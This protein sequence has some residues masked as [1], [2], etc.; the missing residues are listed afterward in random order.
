MGLQAGEHF[1]PKP[2][3]VILGQFLGALLRDLAKRVVESLIGLR[4]ARAP[5]AFGV[6]FDKGGGQ[7]LRAVL[8][9]C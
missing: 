6:K 3:Q 8:T 9:F 7:G 2:A 4:I 5:H 1:A